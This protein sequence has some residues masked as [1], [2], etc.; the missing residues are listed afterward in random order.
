MS[1]PRMNDLVG[2]YVLGALEPD[3]V[4]SFEA[5]MASDAGLAAEVEEARASLLGLAEALPDTEP[6]PELR[7]RVLEQARVTPQGASG[8]APV[9][10]DAVPDISGGREASGRDGGLRVVPWVLLAA[11]L[12]GLF[13][14]GR[15][16]TA[17][18]GEAARLTAQLDSMRSVVAESEVALASLD[19]L[20]LAVSGPNVQFASL[21]GDADPTLRLVWN[22]DRNV[23][24]VA[25]ANLPALGTDRTFQLWGI[26]GSD[27]PVS[28]GTFETEDD[29]SIV[30]ALTAAQAG[31]FEV[32]AV[33]EEPAGGSPQPTSTP[34]LVGAWSARE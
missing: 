34:F 23:L 5:A 33:T 16:R 2:A 27:A 12:A 31:D 32:S 21:S 20:R 3:E 25:A 29:G 6:P 10:P 28:L 14:L 26:R 24:L 22:R 11:S 19:S 4:R 15:E 30:V 9:G 8:A 7:T 17:L 18:Q 13:F 1:D